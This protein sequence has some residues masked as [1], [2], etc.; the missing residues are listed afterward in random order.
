MGWKA[1]LE[2]AVDQILDW[3]DEKVGPHV[4]PK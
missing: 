3:L 2:K 1:L 4:R